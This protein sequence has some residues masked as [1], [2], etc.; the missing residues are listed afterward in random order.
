MTAKLNPRWPVPANWA[1][2]TL[3][4]LG[5]IVGGGT[6]ST[7]D[8][9]YWG[10]EI[11]WISPSDLTGYSNK[12]IKRGAKSISK[13]GL[14]NS[15][16]VVMP[17]GSV[18]FSSRAPV[19]YAV[20]SSRPMATNQGFKSIVPANGVINSYVYYY[21]IASRHYARSRASGTTFL[22]LSG[23]AF[24]ELA[25][26]LA[27]TTEQ[28]RVVAAIEAL[29]S[30][31][32]DG[33][34]S[35]RKARAQLT[36]YRQALLTHAF[37]GKLTAQ[38]RKRNSDNLENRDQLLGRIRK[39]LGSHYQRKVREWETAC[40]A[41]DQRDNQSDRPRKPKKP[42]TIGHTIYGTIPTLPDLPKSW[43]WGKLSWMTC[44]VEYGTAT[45]SAPTGDVPV[46]RMGNI[47]DAKLDWSDL[48]YTS[49]RKEIDRY[50]LKDGD[51]LFN[52]TNSPELVGKTAVYTD[53]RP[54]IFAGYIIRINHIESIVDSQYL[55]LFLNSH[56]A[57]QHGKQRE[58]RRC[59]SIEY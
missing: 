14:A 4:Q 53:S 32:D 50:L 46:L 40:K 15:S 28:H 38:W 42:P 18:H 52:R 27:P 29:L 41:R 2:T 1:W 6:P 7:K 21:L 23:R 59:Q 36:R 47:Q 24:G 39:E 11:P 12:E 5:D 3:S 25:I 31:L 10:D 17:A 13:R 30:E 16:A 37:D 49:S 33:A 22:E 34:V 57:R 9:S 45:K 19:G 54:A 43:I 26:P 35:L 20:I 8:P 56:V 51:V 58:D 55:N 44:G 48:V